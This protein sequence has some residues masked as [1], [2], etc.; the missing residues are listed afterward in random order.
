MYQVEKIISQASLILKKDGIVA[1]P[2]ETVYGLAARINS[3]IAIKEI[4]S[5]KERPFFDPLIVHIGHLNQLKEVTTAYNDPVVLKLAESFWPGPLSIILPKQ[6]NL[7]QMITS[8]LQTVAVRMPNHELALKLILEVGEPLAAP[9]ANKFGKTS[10]TSAK[11]VRESFK[12]NDL[13]I[14]D[15]EESKIGIESTVIKL[16]SNNN[17]IEILRPGYITKNDLLRVLG[18]DFAIEYNTDQSSPGNL[19][20]HYMPDVPLVLVNKI[21]TNDHFQILKKNLG[22]QN[23]NIAELELNYES[24][25]AA[26]Q[27]YYKLREIS[28]NKPDII[29]FSVN[30][31]SGELWNAI[32]D[33]LKRAATYNF[34][35]L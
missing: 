24:V 23:I 22:K 29:L 16:N 26:R 19:E 20:H 15:G 34:S 4:F 3:S 18:S 2:T 28:E 9:S 27:L 35:S 6:E 7:N 1:M 21:L 31:R 12:D 10:P 14:I 32:F 25:I 17:K 30:N 5:K 33:R 11:H 13:F 8:G